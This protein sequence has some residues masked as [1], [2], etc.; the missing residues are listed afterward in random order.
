M[1]LLKDENGNICEHTHDTPECGSCAE[2][3]GAHDG[4]EGH[5]HHHHDHHDHGAN[6]DPNATPDEKMAAVLD[7]MLKH[8]E[9]HAAELDQLAA[10]LL[11]AERPE[12]AEQIRKAVDEFQKGNMYLSLAL[13][14]VREGR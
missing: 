3:C 6:M 9:H 8:N 7:Y 2:H 4:A 1:H 10:K 5:E 12:A 14:T 11:A 13:S